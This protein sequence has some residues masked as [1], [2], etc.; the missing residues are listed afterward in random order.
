[1]ICLQKVGKKIRLQILIRDFDFRR[2]PSISR[3]EI[4]ALDQF[5]VVNHRGIVIHLVHNRSSLKTGTVL[6]C[7]SL[8]LLIEQC[9]R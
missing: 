8:Q 5:E 6:G 3:I 1:M 9:S 7:A 4:L 2:S